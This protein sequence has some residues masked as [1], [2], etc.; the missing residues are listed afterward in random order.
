MV[1]FWHLSKFKQG[2]LLDRIEKEERPCFLVETKK[3]VAVIHCLT[4]DDK[5]LWGRKRPNLPKGSFT[6]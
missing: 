2:V 6:C 3:G 4:K 1:W 5:V